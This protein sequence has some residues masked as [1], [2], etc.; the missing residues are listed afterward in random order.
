[1]AE[2]QNIRITAGKQ[3]PGDAGIVIELECSCGNKAKYLL[4]RKHYGQDK[5]G[6]T[7]T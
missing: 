6:D 4:E 2:E 1:M 3:L 7:T 5:K